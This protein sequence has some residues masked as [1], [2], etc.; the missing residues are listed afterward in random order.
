MSRYF[1]LLA[2]LIVLGLCPPAHAQ[3][4]DAQNTADEQVDEQIDEQI[5]AQR[6]LIGKAS[7][8]GDRP[9]LTAAYIALGDAKVRAIIRRKFAEKARFEGLG[10]GGESAESETYSLVFRY[11]CA[12]GTLCIIK[13]SFLVVVNF[14]TGKVEQ[15]QD[16]YIESS[17]AAPGDCCSQTAEPQGGDIE[18][19]VGI[20]DDVLDGLSCAACLG[21]DECRN[22]NRCYEA[23]RHLRQFLD[24]PSRRHVQDLSD[25]IHGSDR[26][27]NCMK[28]IVNSDRRFRRMMVL[29]AAILA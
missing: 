17:Y 15:I 20:V 14:A 6:E 4:G 13:P 21:S 23:R 7:A 27:E 29:I 18:E 5:D 8:S 1:A 28:C 2:A 3:D 24:D 26:N 11:D 16:P 9:C 19:L 10:C 12:A 22:T 25:F